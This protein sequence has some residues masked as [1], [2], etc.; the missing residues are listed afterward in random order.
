[1]VNV[2]NGKGYT[3]IKV[4]Q[5]MIGYYLGKFAMSYKRVMFGKPGVGTTHSSKFVPIK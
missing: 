2:Y 1:M 3:A 5:E 4:K